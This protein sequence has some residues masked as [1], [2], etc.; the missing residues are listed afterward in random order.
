MDATL[1]DIYFSQDVVVDQSI[2]IGN[3]T[4]ESYFKDK[5][6]KKI[7]GDI[8][9]EIVVILKHDWMGKGIVTGK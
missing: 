3:R 4:S 7:M 5:I 2:W 6:K 1:N 8:S 9:E